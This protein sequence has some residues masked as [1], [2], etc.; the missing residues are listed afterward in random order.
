MIEIFCDGGS[1][2]NPGLAAYGFVVKIEKAT[3][4]KG[5]GV[6][7]I[8]TNNFAEYTAVI[9]ALNWAQKNLKGKDL[10]FYMDSQLVAS[11]LSGLFKIKNAQI[12]ELVFKVRTL[13]TDFGQITY[14]HIP[15][16]KNQ[17]ADSLV[18]QALDDQ[19]TNS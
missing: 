16:E 4:A 17:E 19:K 6:L 8:A 9:E 3:V 18:N 2:G 12:R 1:R 5:L 13:E 7:G 10:N 15:R 11:Q 14:T